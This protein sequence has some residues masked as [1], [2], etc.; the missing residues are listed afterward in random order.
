MPL[1]EYN[2]A[3]GWEARTTIKGNDLITN[4]SFPYVVT[5][6]NGEKVGS[7]LSKCTLKAVTEEHEKA[8]KLINQ[9]A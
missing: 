2:R 4:K 6:Y 1:T 9:K 3:N 5:Y 8:I 7:K